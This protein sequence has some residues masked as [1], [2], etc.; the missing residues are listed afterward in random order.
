M[1]RA[2]GQRAKN[3]E[4]QEDRLFEREAFKRSKGPGVG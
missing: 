4:V 2:V 1:N 3:A